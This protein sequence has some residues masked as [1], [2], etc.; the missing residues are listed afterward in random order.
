MKKIILPVLLLFLVACAKMVQRSGG[1][2]DTMPPQ[3]DTAMSSP[4]IQTNF[5]GDKLEFTFDE[6]IVV[7][8]AL[9]EVIISP[10]LNH[11]PE[12]IA[13]RRTAVLTFNDK[14]TLRENTTYTIQFNDAIG[15]YTEGN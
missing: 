9:K 3:L 11:P 1:P 10:P 2:L 6:F 14:D 12:L 13:K 8:N 15:D 7:Q 5:Q 4:L